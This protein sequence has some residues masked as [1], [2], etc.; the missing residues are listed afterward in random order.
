MRGVSI[1]MRVYLNEMLY[2]ISYALD[3]VEQELVGATGNHAKRVACMCIRMAEALHYSVEDKMN[4][5]AC[6]VLHDCALTEYI[7]VE[8]G[9]Q[10]NLREK[11]FALKSHCELGE[12]NIE[13]MPFYEQVQNVILYHHEQADGSGIFG[14]KVAETPYFARMIHLADQVDVALHLEENSRAKYQELLQ[15]LELGKGSRFDSELVE[16][17]QKA[18]PYE[19]IENLKNENIWKHLTQLLPKVS[20]DYTYQQMRGIAELFARITDYKSTFTSNHSRGVA[21]RAEEM[22]AYYGFSKE[23]QLKLYMAGALYDIGK[24]LVSNDILE[25]PARLS[26]EEFGKMKNHALG[27]YVMLSQIEG[28]EEITSWASLHHEK[29]DGTGYPFGKTAAELGRE[30]RLLACIDIYQALTEARPYKEGM[31]HE[32][33]IGILKNLAEKGQIDGEIVSDLNAYYKNV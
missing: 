14:K 3:S 18:V 9:N 12:R 26:N 25:K 22:G 8:M 20:Y 27:T 2:A 17:F 7:K 31:S 10:S 29:L 11:P 32:K 30:E 15:M 33:T 4:L 23:K 28:F 24:L 6:A 16:L 21:K 13:C 19:E 5:A 1:K